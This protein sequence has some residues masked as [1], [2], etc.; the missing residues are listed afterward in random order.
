MSLEDTPGPKISKIK[1]LSLD[2]SKQ[3]FTPS[4]YNPGISNTMSAKTLN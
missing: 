3:I 2:L 4:S 1:A